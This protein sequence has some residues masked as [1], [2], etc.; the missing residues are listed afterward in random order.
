M[1]FYVVHFYGIKNIYLKRTRHNKF[2]KM[3][4][5]SFALEIKHL[6]FS[7]NVYFSFRKGKHALEKSNR[8]VF[9]LLFSHF[10]LNFLNLVITPIDPN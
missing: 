1:L 7:Q 3:F 6:L 9:R 4:R 5:T 8:T 2:K 10:N